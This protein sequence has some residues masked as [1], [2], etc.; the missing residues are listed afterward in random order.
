MAVTDLQTTSQATVQTA[1]F[2][3]KVVVHRTVT[4][5]ARHLI[6]AAIAIWLSGFIF[7]WSTLSTANAAEKEQTVQTQPASAE[8]KAQAPK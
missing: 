2:G 7:S 8:G 5:Q 1:R 3:E 6:W 4:I